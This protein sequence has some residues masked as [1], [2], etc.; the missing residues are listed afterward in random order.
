[1]FKEIST[2]KPLHAAL[3]EA[4]AIHTLSGRQPKGSV[5]CSTAMGIVVVAGRSRRLAAESHSGELKELMQEDND[6]GM[7]RAV[8]KTVGEI[9]SAFIGRRVGVGILV[10]QLALRGDR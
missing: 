8:T 3:N 9:S 4:I 7:V 5:A 2:T 6:S 10:L 1:V